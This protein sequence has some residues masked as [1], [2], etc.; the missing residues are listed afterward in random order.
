MH[1]ETH[2][3]NT[4]SE[5]RVYMLD[6]DTRLSIEYFQGTEDE[7]PVIRIETKGR[8]APLIVRV[9]EELVVNRS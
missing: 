5:R 4:A 7:R 8:A 1:V 9:D 3:V 2:H 6:H